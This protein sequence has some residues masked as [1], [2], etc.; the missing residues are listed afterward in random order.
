MKEDDVSET[1]FGNKLSLLLKVNDFSN[2]EK[3]LLNSNVFL[4]AWISGEY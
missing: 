2:H 1:K 3:Q 4:T